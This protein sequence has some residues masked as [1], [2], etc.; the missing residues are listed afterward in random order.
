M[1]SDRWIYFSFLAYIVLFFAIIIGLAIWTRKRRR[2][3]P[4]VVFK[5]LRGPG[6]SLRKRIAK[7]DEDSI[8]RVGGAALA[9][10]LAALGVLGIVLKLHPTTW[11]QMFL[12]LGATAVAFIAT[13]FF[14]G[15]WALRDL[16]RYSND[17]LGYLGE[18]EVSEHLEQLLM[19]KRPAGVPIGDGG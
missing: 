8:F 2:D 1:I 3:R 11:P 4:P 19:R 10:V 18:R 16:F 14:A 9:P 6:E 13:L 7:Y 15:R 17:C 12:A 5:L